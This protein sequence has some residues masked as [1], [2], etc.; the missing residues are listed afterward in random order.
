[1]P[2][3]DLPGARQATIVDVAD[4]PEGGFGWYLIRT[5]TQELTYL[6]DGERNLLSMCID[7]DSIQ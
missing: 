1:M 2:G 7:V 5:L 4:L 6:R 3:G